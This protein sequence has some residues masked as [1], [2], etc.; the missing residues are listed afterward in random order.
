MRRGA[1]FTIADR[2]GDFTGKPRPAVIVQSDFFSA[3]ASVTVC[4]ITGEE[5]G[6]VVRVRIDPS[7][8]LPLA[9]ASWAQVDKLTTVRRERIGN[10]IGRLSPDDLQRLN[11]SL[12]VFLGIG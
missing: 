9:K 8:G 4:P 3:L 10:F 7:D 11:G 2:D 12:L 6:S 5:G 1:I